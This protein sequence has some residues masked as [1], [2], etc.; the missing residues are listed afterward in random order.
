MANHIAKTA[1][2]P[3]TAV[4]IKVTSTDEV[5]AI[6]AGEGIAAQAIATLSR[7]AY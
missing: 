4:N 7:R 6:G 2:I 3:L 5:G 1:N